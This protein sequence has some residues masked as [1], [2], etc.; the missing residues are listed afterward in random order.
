MSRFD[1]D[2]AKEANKK[3]KRYLKANGT[4]MQ[5]GRWQARGYENGKLISLGTYD[6]EEEAQIAFMQHRA[7]KEKEGV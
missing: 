3:T 4:R 1:S 2:S 5:K 6:T 7:K